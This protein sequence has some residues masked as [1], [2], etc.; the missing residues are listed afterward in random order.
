MALQYVFDEEGKHTAVLVPI[1]D[2]NTITARH[3][4]VKELVG[5]KIQ[6][7]NNASRFKGLL[8]NEEAKMYDKYLKQ[9]RSEWDRDI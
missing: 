6:K 5:E 2:W 7:T 4:D 1:N 8:T 3:Q 9:A